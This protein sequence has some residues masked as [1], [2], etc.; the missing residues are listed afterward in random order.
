M[1]ISEKS[2]KEVNVPVRVFLYTLDQ[3]GGMIGIAPDLLA[4]GFV[5][6][7]HRSIGVKRQW[8]MMARNIAGPDSDPEWR[9]ADKEFIRWMRNRGFRVIERG[10]VRD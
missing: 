3:I 4:K 10:Y 7:D 9:I 2:Q 8:Q 5:Y 6:F 1:A